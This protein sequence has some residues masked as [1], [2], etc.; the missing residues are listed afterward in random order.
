L[1]PGRQLLNGLATEALE[2]QRDAP[3]VQRLP[4]T[5][6]IDV[7]KTRQHV[8]TAEAPARDRIRLAN[9]ESLSWPLR[10]EAACPQI[11]LRF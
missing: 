1:V 7:D 5:I 3:E 4:Y 10:F 6:V 9:Q 8:G 11:R 2:L